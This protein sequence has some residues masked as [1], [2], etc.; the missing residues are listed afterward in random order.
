MQLLSSHSN[1]HFKNLFYSNKR[2]TKL[3]KP[4]TNVAALRA[5]TFV[6][7]FANFVMAI[8]ITK[9]IPTLYSVLALLPCIKRDRL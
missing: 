6:L 4:K 3:A 5:A 2:F 1:S 7:G 8:T 9:H